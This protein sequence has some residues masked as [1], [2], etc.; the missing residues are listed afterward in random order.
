L[1][2]VI[3]YPRINDYFAKVL[4]AKLPRS[5]TSWEAVDSQGRLF[6]RVWSDQTWDD[7]TLLFWKGRWDNAIGARDRLRCIETIQRG[8]PAYAV[9][10]IPRDPKARIRKIK[11]YDPYRLLRLGDVFEVNRGKYPGT[12]A[13]IAERIPTASV[14]PGR[15][16]NAGL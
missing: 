14:V 4:G 6:F 5:Q 10:C 12:Y 11:D 7:K 13:R 16:R 2:P 9:V 15:L 8:G 3:K 1:D